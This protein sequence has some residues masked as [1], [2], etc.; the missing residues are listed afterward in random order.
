MAVVEGPVIA[1]IAG[2]LCANGIL[3]PLCVFPLIVLGD[4]TGDSIC[5]ALGR[6]GMPKVLKNMVFRFGPNTEKMSR[7]RDYFNAHPVT[8]IS[9][10]KITLGVGFAGIYLAGNARIPYPRFIR[11]CLLTSVA[12]YL[13]YL[14][15]GILFGDAY[16]GI[17][18]YLNEIAALFLLAGA[19]LLFFFFIQSI[20]KKI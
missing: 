10:S 11:I 19:A 16:I 2:F 17:S 15:I 7:V 6:R 5:Y 1:I 18:R 4:I 14:G 20:I 9:L 12:Q 13:I 8:T 3:N